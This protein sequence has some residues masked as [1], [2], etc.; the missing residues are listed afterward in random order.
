MRDVFRRDAFTLGDGRKAYLVV[1][2]GEV[3]VNGVTL[4]ER[5]GAALQDETTIAIEAKQDAEIVLVDAP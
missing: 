1:A 4:R 5:D 2:K 3:T